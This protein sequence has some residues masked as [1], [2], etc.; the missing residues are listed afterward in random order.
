[1]GVP[2]R[3]LFAFAFAAAATLAVVAGYHRPGENATE[4]ARP[5][6]GR[7]TISKSPVKPVKPT[8]TVGEAARFLNQATFGATDAEAMALTASSYNAWLDKQFTLPRESHYQHVL[9]LKSIGVDIDDF[10]NQHAIESFWKQAITGQDQLRQRVTWGLSQI[11]V[12]GDVNNMR[13]SAYYDVLAADAF[14]NFRTLLEDVTLSPA[15]GYWLSH[16]GNKKE[17]PVT[18]RL[19]DENYAREVMQLFTIGLWKLNPDGTRMLDGLGK[20]I[21][22]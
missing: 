13:N 8:I 21:P 3:Y 12:V 1:M 17:D 2:R 11:F 10:T 7:V 22:T 18:G 9:Y 5:G 6:A 14:G 19:P 15:M 20:P 16:I 4:R